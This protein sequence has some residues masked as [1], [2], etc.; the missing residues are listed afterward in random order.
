MQLNK[1]TIPLDVVFAQ[2]D[3][4][5]IMMELHTFAADQTLASFSFKAMFCWW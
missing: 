1:D 4:N 5:I 2:K 3:R